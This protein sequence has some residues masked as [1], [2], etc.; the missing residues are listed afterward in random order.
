M[1]H[2][3]RLVSGML[4]FCALA[5]LGAAA[6]A[7]AQTFPEPGDEAKLYDA[8]KKDGTVVV[9]FTYPLDVVNAL[10]AEFGKKYPGVRLDPLRLTGLAQY[11]R[12]IQETEA[13]QHNA[14]LI[15]G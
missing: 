6:P 2:F 4:G 11:Q 3:S 13:K 7:A 15:A 8:A 9:Y 5:A 10:G 1:T 12:F 14:D